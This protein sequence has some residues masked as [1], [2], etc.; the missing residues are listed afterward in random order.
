MIHMVLGPSRGGKSAYAEHLLS[1]ASGSKKLYVG[2]LPRVASYYEI[3]AHHECRRPADWALLELTADL[4]LDI[5]KLRNALMCYSHILLDGL[6][7]YIL[8]LDHANVQACGSP[9][10]A[11]LL[12][13]AISMATNVILV[14]CP[15]SFALPHRLKELVLVAHSQILNVCDEVTYVEA[16]TIRSIDAREAL[17]LD[18]VSSGLTGISR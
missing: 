2:T 11:S 1:I 8:R 16:T 4:E 15:V 10:L 5:A 6:T 14:D 7:F 12:R 18:F 17:Q 3:I 9:A 13:E